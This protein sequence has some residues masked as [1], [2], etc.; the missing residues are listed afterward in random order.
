MHHV[1]RVEY[2]HVLSL[3]SIIDDFLI[4]LMPPNVWR[5]APHDDHA[6]NDGEG[7][8]MSGKGVHR[9]FAKRGFTGGS[10]KGGG[11]TRGSQKGV[12]VNHVNPL[13]RGLQSYA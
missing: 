6:I 5:E 12:H 3:L 8:T 1:H 11:F 7:F 9:A 4:D 10:R 13:A 2:V